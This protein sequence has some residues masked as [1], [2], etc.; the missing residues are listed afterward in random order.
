[1]FLESEC[2][3]E[4]GARAGRQRAY[5]RYRQ[6]ASTNGHAP[7]SAT[8]FNREVRAIYP[9][10]EEEV[11]D[12]RGGDRMFVG[13]RLQEENDLLGQFRLLSDD[14]APGA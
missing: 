14:Q 9:Q 13:F 7:V 8:R 6:W 3:T 11:R 10:P 12:G 4:P 1:M 5:A 2:V